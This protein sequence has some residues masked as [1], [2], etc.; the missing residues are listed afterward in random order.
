MT[1]TLEFTLNSKPLELAIKNIFDFVLKKTG[2]TKTLQLP[3]FVGDFNTRP[4]EPSYLILTEEY[5]L[6]KTGSTESKGQRSNKS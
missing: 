6:I 2:Y 1:S 3:F 4:D 5:S